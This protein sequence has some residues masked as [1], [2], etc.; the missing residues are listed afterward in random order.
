MKR[1]AM[2]FAG[3]LV[4]GAA[5][6]GGAHA[7]ED[8]DPFLW[9]ED[10]HGQKALDWVA[11][12]N[13]ITLDKLKADPSYSENYDALL[14]MLDADDRIPAGQLHGG[15]VFNFWQDREHVKG[16]WRQ[17]AI[18]SYESST[19]QW[20]T[21]LDLDRLSSAEG[22]NWVFK[23]AICSGD[24]SRCLLKLSPDGGDTVVLREFSPAEKR[25]LDH[26]FS[27]GEAKAEA[28]YVDAN[29]ILFSTDFGAGTLTRAGYP[30]IVKLWHRGQSL[31][32]ARQV[33][34]AKPED[35]IASPVT[36]DSPQGSIA[37]ISRAVSYFETEYYLVT[38]DGAAVRLPLPLS[39]EVRGALHAGAPDEQLI[40]SSTRT[41]RR[42]TTS[43]RV[44]SL[45]TRRAK[46]RPTGGGRPGRGLCVHLY[47][48]DGKHTCVPSGC[49]G[50]VA[51]PR[52][53]APTRRFG[54]GPVRQRVRS[55]GLLQFPGF[56]HPRDDLR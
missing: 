53:C 54:V 29:T 13:A 14:M 47:E 42:R 18:A 39:A 30:R 51:R 11:G 25:F 36:Y 52:R 44:G 21:L 27:L 37:L 20:D 45:C 50:H 24:R 34:E 35:V 10:I 55:G 8:E 19:P 28:A 40:A 4:L 17:T 48:C 46:R 38:P 33:F 7:M 32:E 41:H 9:L 49:G 1:S 2:V 43:A 15:Q 23:G 3:A 5:L 22:K 16:V 31:A 12:Q 26:G 6:A 56:S